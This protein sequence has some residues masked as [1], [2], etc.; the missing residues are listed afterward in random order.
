MLLQNSQ[1]FWV[2]TV[3]RSYCGCSSYFSCFNP[4]VLVGSGEIPKFRVKVHRGPKAP[5]ALEAS[6]AVLEDLTSQLQSTGKDAASGVTLG[7]SGKFPVFRGGF[8]G[9]I[10]YKW[11]IFQ[12]LMKVTM[13]NLTIKNWE[14]EHQNHGDVNNPNDGDFRMKHVDVNC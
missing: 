8:H 11:R 4:L 9:K 5:V 13:Q 12:P 1:I 14:L 10:I 6:E 3:N 2:V 7:K